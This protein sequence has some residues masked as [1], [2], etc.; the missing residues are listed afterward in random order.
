MWLD[1][2]LAIDATNDGPLSARA[3]PRPPGP[4]SR[5]PRPR[6]KNLGRAR[7]QCVSTALRRRT[8]FE[9][10]A[11]YVCV[12]LSVCLSVCLCLCLCDAR[13]MVSIRGA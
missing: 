5:A 11:M 13:L 4:P 7:R 12:C 3:S 10:R 9:R 8:E 2:F 6:E 1:V